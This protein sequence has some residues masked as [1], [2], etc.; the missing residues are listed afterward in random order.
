ME[1][2]GRT[3][4]VGGR[5]IYS[6][7]Q[8][9]QPV[10]ASTSRDFIDYAIRRDRVFLASFSPDRDRPA[11]EAAWQLRGDEARAEIDQFEPHYEGSGILWGPPNGECSAVGHHELR[12]R[13]GHHLAPLCLSSG[14][15]VYEE[16]GRDFT[17]LAFDAAPSAVRAFADAAQALGVPLKGIEDDRRDGRAGYEAC[18]ILVRPDQFVAWSSISAPPDPAL[19]L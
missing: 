16:L 8:E 1:T 6:Y 15:N 2:G 12:A 4:R 7:C 18:L 10:F 14:R 17:L 9:R 3:P 19:I 5:P 13:P 11:F